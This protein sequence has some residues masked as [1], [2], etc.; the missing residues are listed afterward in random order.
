MS[1]GCPGPPAAAILVR[2]IDVI[3]VGTDGSATADKAVEF[4]MDLASRYEAELVVLS[5]YS[6]QP[7]TLASAAMAGAWVHPG[8]LEWNPQEAER[9]EELLARTKHRAE[10]RGM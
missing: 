10:Q 4:A 7:S 2:M 1:G 8:P 5:A 3:A 6:S 9:V